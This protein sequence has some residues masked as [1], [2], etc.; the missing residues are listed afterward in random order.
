MGTD[1]RRDQYGGAVAGFGVGLTRP[2]GITITAPG[3]AVAGFGV[4]LTIG[5]MVGLITK[6][7]A[8]AVPGDPL[9]E[10]VSFFQIFFSEISDFFL[11]LMVVVFLIFILWIYRLKNRLL[12]ANQRTAEQQKIISGLQSSQSAHVGDIKIRDQRIKQLWQSR[13]ELRELLDHL[14]VPAWMRD[15]SLDLIFCNRAYET[16]VAASSQDAVNNNLEVLT[17]GRFLAERAHSTRLAQSESGHVVVDQQRHLIEVTETPL[18]NQEP[19]NELQPMQGMI[20][21]ARDFTEIESVRDELERHTDAHGKVLENLHIAIAIFGPDKKLKFFNS[22]Y[23]NLWRLE[24]DWLKEEPEIGQVFDSLRDNRRLP[25]IIDFQAFKDQQRQLFTALVEP[26]EDLLH[27]P[28]GTTI[29]AIMTP[30]PLGGIL[31][32]YEDVTDRLTLERSYHTLNATQ[33]E[34]LNN[35]YEGIAVFGDDGRLKLSN[36]AFAAIWGL[37]MPMLKTRPHIGELA[38][39]LCQQFSQ[40][41]NHEDMRTR[42]IESVTNPSCR[43]GRF[44]RADGSSIDYGSVPLPDGSVLFTYEDVT[45]QMQIERALRERAEAMETAARM[46]SEFIANVSYQLRTPL[47]S[48]IGF[49]QMLEKQYFGAL[50]P[51]QQEY[52][53]GILNA[54]QELM[55]LIDDILDMTQIEAGY[56]R[57]ESES[58]LLPDFLSECLSLFKEKATQ[59]NVTMTTQIADELPPIHADR[60]RLRQALFNLLNNAVKFTPAQ[61]HIILMAAHRENCVDISVQDNGVGIPEEDQKRILDKFEKGNDPHTHG[62]G[63]GLSLVKALAELHGGILTLESNPNQGTKI[64][65]TLPVQHPSI[66]SI[67]ISSKTPE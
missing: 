65:M 21:W 44:H 33:R 13:N 46:K 51:R 29:C 17:N 6:G 41:D 15:S 47:N 18:F 5:L 64:T 56:I 48:I 25:E 16:V 58:I 52:N 59:S 34:T 43:E 24:E 19:D 28:D 20:G 26:R 62:L 36:P 1:G 30:H 38:T 37:S 50:N 31:F 39:Q 14:P 22:S 8:A 12:T 54:S 9:A 66:D 49:S 67:T 53:Q 2:E 40:Q 3:S 7:A 55:L 23:A 11:G 45:D 61:G 60:R 42:L 57:L 10:Y 27:L 63:L 35:L 4:G 32:T